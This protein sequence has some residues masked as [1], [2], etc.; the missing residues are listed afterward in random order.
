MSAARV[1]FKGLALRSSVGASCG[2]EKR[3]EVVEPAAL[4]PARMG[5]QCFV[6][7]SD[8]MD[9]GRCGW[10]LYWFLCFRHNGWYTAKKQLKRSIPSVR[11]PGCDSPNKTKQRKN[12]VCCIST[13]IMI[14]PVLFWYCPGLLV[15][16]LALSMDNDLRVALPRMDSMLWRRLQRRG[17]PV[18]L[19]ARLLRRFSISVDLD[20]G[21]K[22]GSD[23]QSHLGPPKLYQQQQAMR[24]SQNSIVKHAWSSNAAYFP[25]LHAHK[26][27]HKSAGTHWNVCIDVSQVSQ[28]MW[29]TNVLSRYVVA[30][31]LFYHADK[32]DYHRQYSP[33]GFVVNRF[34]VPKTCHNSDDNQQCVMILI[35]V[36]FT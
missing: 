19:G 32:C 1:C 23:R 27:D 18:F 6:I 26:T 8:L 7:Q 34:V 12:I 11:R 28:K 4:V 17:V 13:I 21:R 15:A 3:R 29:S 35:H 24:E 33:E 2:T 9:Q 30:I 5:Y 31:L 36:P 20:F 22:F 10:R 16:C 14:D 25:S